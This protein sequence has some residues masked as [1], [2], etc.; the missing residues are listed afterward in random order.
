M[1]SAPP[2]QSLPAS[3]R[4]RPS[5]PQAVRRR[6]FTWMLVV[7]APLLALTL[8]AVVL[9]TLLVERP[10]TPLPPIP[11]PLT[12]LTQHLVLLVMD[13][14]RY[15][16]ATDPTKAPLLAKRMAE[17]PSARV[18]AGQI[19]MT[20]AAV[21]SFGT[22]ARGDFAQVVTN[23]SMSR[24]RQND[25][26]KNAH[27]SGRTTALVG[28]RTWLDAFGDEGFDQT[29]T[30]AT[31]LA[32]DVDNSPEMFAEASKL[33]HSASPPSLTVVHFLATDHFGHAFGTTDERYLTML[34]TFDKNL[35]DFLHELPPG[36]TVIGLSDHGATATGAHGSDIWSVRQTPLFAF[37]PGIRARTND[38]VFEQVDVAATLATLIGVPVPAESRGTVAT[39]LLDLDNEQIAQV[40]AAEARRVEPIVGAEGAKR[41]GEAAVRAYDDAIVRDKESRGLSASLGTFLLLF[42]G[43]IGAGLALPEL[44]TWTR[45]ASIRWAAALAATATASVFLTKYVELLVPPFHNVVRAVLFVVGNVVLLVWAFAPTKLLALVTRAPSLLLAL[46]PGGLA[47]SYTANTQPEA[48]VALT[49]LLL[50]G[51]VR[52]GR[53]DLAAGAL[54]LCLALHPFGYQNDDPFPAWLAAR[55]TPLFAGSLVA[56]VAWAFAT[57]IARSAALVPRALAAAVPIVCFLIADRIGPPVGITLTLL[58]PVVV[59]VAL[60]RGHG[61]L[62]RN[63]TLGSFLLLARDV[64][65]LPVLALATLAEW[66]PAV[67]AKEPAPETSPD[68][69]PQTPDL[70]TGEGLSLFAHALVLFGIYFLARVAI[71]RGLDFD[72]LHFGAGAFGSPEP[73]KIWVG[74]MMGYRYAL[75]GGLLFAVAIARLPARLRVPAMYLSLVLWFGRGATLCTM[76]IIGR[77]SYWTAQRT[78]SDVSPAL[79]VTV[80]LAVALGFLLRTARTAR[81]DGATPPAPLAS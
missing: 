50:S 44:S 68:G 77:T 20:S 41:G 57:P 63:V 11:A 24:T 60:R 76:L 47:F 15:D 10:P 67:I 49:L 22:G 54:L 21:L 66:S 74:V 36:L 2:P 40:R 55:H 4:P 64:E 56:L 1:D 75:V 25:L 61:L 7:V 6:P 31:G 17:G 43:A 13:G 29:H 32:L 42:A 12:P 45:R 78:I 59:I 28:D 71:Q 62:A 19:T 58:A 23:L 3:S 37:G 38:L 65:V 51:L 33:L 14:L 26:F 46:V 8:V 35:D 69:A 34:R 53:R 52:A 30:D 39:A 70:V 16:Y 27:A 72:R 79:I 73:N 18:V 5:S 80:V 48:F 9:R 81:I